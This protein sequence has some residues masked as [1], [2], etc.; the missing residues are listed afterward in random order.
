MARKR[1]TK[2]A[3]GYTILVV[4]DQEAALT[5]TKLVLESEGHRVLLADSGRAALE[6]FDELEIHLL[7]VDY[8]MPQMTGEKLVAAIRERDADVQIVLQTGYSGEKP[9]RVK[10]SSSQCLSMPCICP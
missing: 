8:F 4:D 10:S 9:P 3:S 1:T 2:A 5:S 7:L 6:I